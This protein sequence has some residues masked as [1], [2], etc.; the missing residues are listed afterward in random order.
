[1]RRQTVV[2]PPYRRGR[3]CQGQ[4]LCSTKGIP[5]SVLRSSARGYPAFARGGNN[6]WMIPYWSAVKRTLLVREV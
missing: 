2:S 4:P 5:A 6:G 3:S 1:M